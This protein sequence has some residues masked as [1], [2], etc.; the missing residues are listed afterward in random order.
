[1]P[2][3]DPRE[4]AKDNPRARH[5]LRDRG[6]GRRRRRAQRAVRCGQ[7]LHELQLTGAAKRGAADRG[8]TR[9]CL[10]LRP[11]GVRAGGLQSQWHRRSALKLGAPAR[12][13]HPSH[14]SARP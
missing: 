7:Q 11:L 13:R 9:G 1:M 14:S 6:R 4:P 5:A 3:E 2:C 10:S 8:V 12:D